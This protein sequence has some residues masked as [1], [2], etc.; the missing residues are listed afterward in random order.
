[1]ENIIAQ[2]CREADAGGISRKELTPFL[3]KRV[4]EATSG[5][6]LKANIALVRN[7]ARLAAQIAVEHANFRRWTAG[8]RICF[9]NEEEAV[10]LTGTGVRT[11]NW[12]R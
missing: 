3:L 1:M 5:K 4:N 7:N 9:P 6:S 11:S 8:A 10:V 12:R 2:A